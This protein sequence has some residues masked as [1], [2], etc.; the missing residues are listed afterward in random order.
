MRDPIDIQVGLRLRL[1]R[2]SRGLSQST[3]GKHLGIS[4]Q[5]VQKYE[6][7]TNR[8]TPSRLHM[9]SAVLDT[10]VSRFF[11]QDTECLQDTASPVLPSK[12]VVDLVEAYIRLTDPKRKATVM[13]LLESLADVD[14]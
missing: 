3:L 2:K 4:F 9:I 12:D 7:G 13:A 14:V 6:N 5:Q 1:F 11:D 8:V 10:P